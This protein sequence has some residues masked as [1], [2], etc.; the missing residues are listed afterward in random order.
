MSKII[1]LVEEISEDGHLCANGIVHRALGIET[2]RNEFDDDFLVFND[3]D[4][5]EF[6]TINTYEITSDT[7]VFYYV[8][9]KDTQEH[10]NPVWVYG[11]QPNTLKKLK[12]FNI[13]I[14]INETQEFF[15]D[16]MSEGRPHRSS[17][18]AD[19]LDKQLTKLGLIRNNIIINGVANLGDS[20]PNLQF[21]NRTYHTNFSF[22]F[23]NRAQYLIKEDH[24]KSINSYEDNFST[25]KEKLSICIN[26]QPR[27]LR[28]T[29][30]ALLEPFRKNSIFTML[31][32]EPLNNKLN[33]AEIKERFTSNIN[34]L[35]DD[36][37]K[38]Q[39][40]ENLDSLLP[41]FPHEFD[42]E[43]D[44]KNQSMHT[45]INEEIN[46]AR[47][48]CF[49]ELV[50][51]THDSKYKDIDVSIITEK[52]LWPIIN[53]IPFAIVGH[54]GN[55]RFLKKI[56]FDLFEKSLLSEEDA[57][58]SYE[59]NFRTI[60][61]V[62]D[63]MSGDNLD[64]WVKDHKDACDL[65]FNVLLNTDWKKVEVDRLLSFI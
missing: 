43:K 62:Y 17:S 59:H 42:I 24:T 18:S 1:L 15:L 44:K 9:V 22:Y 60:R 29:L 46:L 8:E 52:A 12:K 19:L 65:N 40:L 10:L 41:D 50:T 20:T 64:N 5:F 11:I 35:K 31:G 33:E 47:R 51:E 2:K 36:D 56:G 37:I 57:S 55:Y 14:I 4:Y 26:R 27:E 25:P 3:T 54:R 28:C 13:P 32:E 16:Y 7:K 61:A 49:F 53:R 58:H 39:A 63:R 45:N 48:K 30:L 38:E 6:H 21:A 23:F 34:L